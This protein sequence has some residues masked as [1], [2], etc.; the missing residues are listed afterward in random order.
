M[1]VLTCV[2]HIATQKRFIFYILVPRYAAAACS[3]DLPLEPN[4]NPKLPR[5]QNDRVLVRWRGG[6]KYW[7]AVVLKRRGGASLASRK[8][9]VADDDEG[10]D[11]EGGGGQGSGRSVSGEEGE[12]EE[13]ED[14][15]EDEED[16]DPSPFE[17]FDVRYLIDGE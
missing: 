12:E 2:K 17:C 7:D 16:E 15:E 5:R 4:I 13:E 3:Q 1:L 8:D 10:G 6:R 9:M 11:G 14:E